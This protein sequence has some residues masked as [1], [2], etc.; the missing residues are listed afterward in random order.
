M[1]HAIIE[2]VFKSEQKRRQNQI[3]IT[4]F[5]PDCLK[6]TTTTSHTIHL[7]AEGNEIFPCRCGETHKGPYA[8][9]DY[10]HH[11]C[12]HESH[13]VQLDPYYVLCQECGNTWHTE[14]W[15]K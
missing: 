2:E 7:Y 9:Y 6:I 13:L 4:G 11:E 8:A 1:I 14:P 15:R 10:G 12:F 3:G 5:V